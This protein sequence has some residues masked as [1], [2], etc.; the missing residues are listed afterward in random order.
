MKTDIKWGIQ[1]KC[2]KLTL[3]VINP[4]GKTLLLL[5][6]C[7]NRQCASLILEN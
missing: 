4:E 1:I 3:L 5:Y 2:D 7:V 6:S